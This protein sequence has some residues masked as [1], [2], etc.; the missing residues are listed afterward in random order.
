[1]IAI[2]QNGHRILVDMESKGRELLVP[3]VHRPDL[4]DVWSL[5]VLTDDKDGLCLVLQLRTYMASGVVVV[6]VKVQDTM[7][8]QVV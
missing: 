1:M 7:D 5:F 4:A 6:L 3:H 2:L 8:M